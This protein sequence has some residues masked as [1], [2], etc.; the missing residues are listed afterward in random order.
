MKYADNI[1]KGFATSISIIVTSVICIFIPAFQFNPT[2]LFLFGTLVVMIACCMYNLDTWFIFPG[3]EETI[4]GKRSSMNGTHKYE[5]ISSSDKVPSDGSRVWC[6]EV[7][8][9]SSLLYEWGRWE[10]VWY[11]IECK[12]D[13]RRYS[14]KKKRS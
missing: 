7:V 14:T 9:D 11:S 1:I 8:M 2:P 6:E 13:G 4:T 12:D 10:W 3:C 5:N